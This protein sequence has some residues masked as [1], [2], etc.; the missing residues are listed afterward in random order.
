[1]KLI[2]FLVILSLIIVIAEGGRNN[3]NRRNKKDLR[4]KQLT[5]IEN[6]QQQQNRRPGQHRPQ[7]RKPRQH[8]ASAPQQSRPQKQQQQQKRKQQPV[9]N[10]RKQ[11]INKAA[12]LGFNLPDL[13]KLPN[14]KFNCDDDDQRQSKQERA[15]CR[16]RNNCL[17][18]FKTPKSGRGPTLHQ[19]MEICKSQAHLQMLTTKIENVN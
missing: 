12:E 17:K 19:K 2:G 14:T 9:Q 6:Q 8:L 11:P 13:K 4:Q 15:F 18:K 5:S 10:P 3:G 7:R 1:M 16:L